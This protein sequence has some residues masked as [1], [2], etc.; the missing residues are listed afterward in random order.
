MTIWQICE[1]DRMDKIIS[2]PLVSEG[3]ITH[4]KTSNLFNGEDGM[5]D[6]E[7]IVMIHPICREG[8]T[9]KKQVVQVSIAI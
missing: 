4:P 6:K 2:H 8:K 5:W 3:T 9:A 1:T 7:K